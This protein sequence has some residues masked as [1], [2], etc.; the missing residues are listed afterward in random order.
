MF[1]CGEDE[2]VF[3]EKLRVTARHKSKMTPDVSKEPKEAE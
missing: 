2:A 1:G 3:A